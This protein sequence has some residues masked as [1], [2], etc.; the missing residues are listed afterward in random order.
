[1]CQMDKAFFWVRLLFYQDENNRLLLSGLR[2]IGEG[3]GGASNP[4]RYTVIDNFSDDSSFF[5]R[6]GTFPWQDSDTPNG[7][8]CVT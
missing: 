8:D 1:M 5:E 2:D 6:G 7:Q 4:Q 3:T